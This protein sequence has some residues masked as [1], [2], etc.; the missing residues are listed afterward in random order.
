MHFDRA[1]K[2]LGRMQWKVIT[3]DSNGGFV[4]ICNPNLLTFIG[5]NQWSHQNFVAQRETS[6]DTQK[7]LV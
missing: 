7:L 5:V 1:S 3:L 4:Q 2:D 6:S